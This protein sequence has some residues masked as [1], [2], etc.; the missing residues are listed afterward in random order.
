VTPDD[1]FGCCLTTVH[2]NSQAG[3][4]AVAS[5][6]ADG[7]LART[8][9]EAVGVGAATDPPP[10]AATS[11]DRDSTADPPRTSG[12]PVPIA[13]SLSGAC[14]KRGG[15]VSPVAQRGPGGTKTVGRASK[16]PAPATV[17]R[18]RGVSKGRATQRT[19]GTHPPEPVGIRRDRPQAVGPGTGQGQSRRR[20]PRATGASQAL[21]I[22][23]LPA[24]TR[25]LWVRPLRRLHGPRSD[26]DLI[27]T[28]TR[29]P[30]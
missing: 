28:A 6:P 10:H 4:V 12:F 24:T 16:P 1:A 23:A 3:A 19:A 30:M 18:T 7:V 11:S 13:P 8:A 15:P 26:P 22:R 20:S 2:F 21:A 27:L 5:D 9:T 17:R 25:R 14:P 29:R